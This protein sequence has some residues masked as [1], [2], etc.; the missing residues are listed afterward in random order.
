[1]A[2]Q[3]AELG[4]DLEVL[5]LAI[6]LAESLRSN[7]V[8]R[9]VAGLLRTTFPGVVF[10]RYAWIAHL[11]YQLMSFKLKFETKRVGAFEPAMIF[12]LVS[13]TRFDIKSMYVAAWM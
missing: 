7:D 4:A 13:R 12:Q 6:A 11:D 3:Q 9:Y 10:A 5:E 1:M 2:N 8:S